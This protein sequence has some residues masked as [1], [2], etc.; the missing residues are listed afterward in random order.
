MLNRVRE[1]RP[2]Y[3]NTQRIS[4][5]I[6]VSRLKLIYYQCFA[7]AYSFC[8]KFVDI[9]IVNSSWTKHHIE[10]LW[11]KSSSNNSSTNILHSNN[12]A[13]KQL[14]WFNTQNITLIYPPCNTLPLTTQKAAMLH[15]NTAQQQEPGDEQEQKERI[16]EEDQRTSTAT[17]SIHPD[18]NNATVNPPSTAATTAASI[19]TSSSSSSSSALWQRHRVIVSVGQFRPEKDHLLQIKSME[20]FIM[21]N[22]I[23]GNHELDDVILVMLGSTR[24]QEDDT[25]ADSLQAY[26]QSKD[27]LHHRIYI[28][29]NQPY[30]ILQEYLLHSE[31]GL[32]TMWNEHFGISVVEMLAAGLITI[33]HNSGGPK[34]DIIQHG[35]NG[36]LATE[37]EEYAELFRQV[38]QSPEE[39]HR[40]KRKAMQSVYRFSD[41]QFIEDMVDKMD[42]VLSEVF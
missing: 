2:S 10:E 26:I 11:F 34:S 17:T 7:I 36:Y 5:N 31:V 27:Y 24:H 32:H 6:A 8:G 29:R 25:L 14:L 20:S 28:L 22:Q 13:A 9:V 37:P 12:M 4:S 33:A 30:S 16:L 39:H 1:Q 18:I 38:F 42:I 19:T 41:D 15:S 35:D 40:M 3:N 23:Q 21:A